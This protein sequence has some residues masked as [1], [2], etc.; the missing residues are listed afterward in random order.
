LANVSEVILGR[1]EAE[2]SRARG[3]DMCVGVVWW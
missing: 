2:M 3:G 1:G